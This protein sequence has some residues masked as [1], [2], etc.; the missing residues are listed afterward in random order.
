MES[1]ESTTVPEVVQNKSE[2]QHDVLERSAEKTEQSSDNQ[3]NRTADN[4]E[5]EQEPQQIRRNSSTDS[6]SKG[7][8]GLQRSS[9]GRKDSKSKKKKEKFPWTEKQA[10][11]LLDQYP[12][13]YKFDAEE[14][15]D[16]EDKNLLRTRSQSSPIFVPS[17]QKNG[18]QRRHSILKSQSANGVL[19]N[20]PPSISKSEHQKDEP[21]S[22]PRGKPRSTTESIK[23]I[24]TTTTS[25]DQHQEIKKPQLSFP[26]VIPKPDN[27]NHSSSMQ[28]LELS[29]HNN[30]ETTDTE[31]EGGPNQTQ[32]ENDS[33]E[34]PTANEFSDDDDD[35]DNSSTQS[36]PTIDSAVSPKTARQILF[37]NREQAENLLLDIVLAIRC[38]VRIFF[39]NGKLTE[40]QIL[41]VSG[42]HQSFMY[43]NVDGEPMQAAPFIPERDPSYAFTSEKV[44]YVSR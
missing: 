3:V 21:L 34:P 26:L 19:D 28:T 5:G 39:L 14:D 12:R 13:N 25:N 38:C 44:Y 37:V 42:L 43:Y 16:T 17:T 31:S 22:S 30:Q 41:G 7:N 36:A 24:T 20:K 18:S 2:V 8:N 40:M 27:N 9:S 1:T 15:N 10:E 35:D 33:S 23:P 6:N 32:Q 29:I 11:L 4:N